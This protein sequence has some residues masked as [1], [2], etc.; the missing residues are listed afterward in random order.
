M[1]H[2]IQ[3]RALLQSLVCALRLDLMFPDG[4]SLDK[5]AQ[6]FDV[7][8]THEA[9][10]TITHTLSTTLIGADGKVI[11]FYPGNDWTVDQVLARQVEPRAH[12]GHGEEERGM[13]KNHA[14]IIQNSSE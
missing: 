11:R 9:D 10:S 5:M 6:W 14:G 1:Y 4:Q 13:P 12:E 2:A 7:G 3:P 8:L